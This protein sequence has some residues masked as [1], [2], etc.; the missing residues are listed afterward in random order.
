MGTAALVA[1]MPLFLKRVV[2]QYL[3]GDSIRP[4]ILTMGVFLLAMLFRVTFWYVGQSILLVVQQ[5][6]IFDLRSSVFSNIQQLCLR[7]HDRYSPGYLYDRTLGT[8]STSIGQFLL[9]FNNTIVTGASILLFSII[10]CLWISP[11]MTLWILLASGFYVLIS[12]YFG[13][14][15][16]KQTRSYNEAANQFAG[17]VTDLLRGVRTIQAFAMEKRVVRQFNDDLW[18]LQLRWVQ[19]SREHLKL[20]LLGES[21]NYLVY[22][23]VVVAGSH[24]VIKRKLTLGELV[25]FIAYF[26][27]CIGLISMLAG[28][29]TAI[30]AAWAGMEQMHEIIEAKSSVEEQPN[31]IAPPGQIQ[32]GLDLEHITFSYQDRPII[33]NLSLHIPR[34]QSVALVGPSGGGKTTVL[35]LL[36][37][38]YD[39]EQGCVRFD[40]QNIR[41]YTLTGWRGLFG[42]VL[43]DPFLFNDSI[44]NNL[45]SV[46]PDASDA[47]LQDVLEKSCAW[48][49]VSQL[50]TGWHFCVGE[51]GSRLS[52]GQKQRIAIARCFLL[53]PQIVLLDEATSALDTQSERH[54][55]KAIENI[56]GGRNV[57]IIA[58][59]LST[60]RHV[61]RILVMDRG[62]IVQDGN[63]QQLS[64]LPG[65]FR[66]LYSAK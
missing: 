63:W 26:E 33:Q 39:P 12:V 20:S 61:D 16:H 60:I 2:D 5:R 22:A 23:G 56:T 38:F 50:E 4:V 45:K 44:Y 8:A 58:H 35:N 31:A 29:T 40:G 46:R 15:I 1:T 18:P 24:L 48:E 65:L 19:L 54:V 47:T 37:R 7:F 9:V 6:V 55:Q 10:F 49:F 66:D 64:Q 27:H 28:S 36:L 14:V 51:N 32:T 62:Q 52:G 11:L 57:F 13:H 17:K 3:K 25:A 42:V 30:A 41:Q 21:M 43:Q 59:R 53:D 34:G